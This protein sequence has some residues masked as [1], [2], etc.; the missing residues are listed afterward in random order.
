MK[1][2]YAV[3]PLFLPIQMPPCF[4]HGEQ[5]HGKELLAHAVHCA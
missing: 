4:I 1:E 5:G 3:K 2:N